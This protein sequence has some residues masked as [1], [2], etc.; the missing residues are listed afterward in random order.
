VKVFC[1]DCL[2]DEPYGEPEKAEYIIDGASFCAIHALDHL[3]RTRK[4]AA[5]LEKKGKVIAH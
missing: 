3:R 2:A 5:K 4:P 1:V